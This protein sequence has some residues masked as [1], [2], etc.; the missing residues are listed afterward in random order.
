MVK[1]NVN[2]LTFQVRRPDSPA[3]SLFNTQM[4]KILSSNVRTQYR[5]LGLSKASDIPMVK[6]ENGYDLKLAKEF[7]NRQ[8]KIASMRYAPLNGVMSPQELAELLDEQFGEYVKILGN[9]IDGTIDN[10]DQFYK[11]DTLNINTMT[12]YEKLALGMDT[13]NLIKTLPGGYEEYKILKKTNQ[14]IAYTGYTL[15]TSNKGRD[16]WKPVAFLSESEFDVLMLSLTK[17]YEASKNWRRN[18]GVARENYVVAMKELTRSLL[19]GISPAEIESKGVEDI[20]DMISGLNERSD[21][22]KIHTIKDIS[23]PEKVSDE[24]L[25]NMLSDFIGKYG[26]L[27]KIREEYYFTFY[28]NDTKYYWLPIEFLP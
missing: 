24:E 9:Q 16:Y 13:M 27:K 4:S 8:Y 7:G 26:F 23:M 21:A 6:V 11:F 18:P 3:Y 17:L 19:P 1:S 15:K 25:G 5:E 28:V 10:L 12:D 2:L 20:M 22:L 14:L